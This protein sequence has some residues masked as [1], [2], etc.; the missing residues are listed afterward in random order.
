MSEKFLNGA[1]TAELWE[2]MKGYVDARLIGQSYEAGNGIEF[3]Q[4][5]SGPVKINVE[6]PVVPLTNADYEALPEEQKNS[7]TVFL[8]TD[9]NGASS[10]DSS[11]YSGEVYS[12]EESR[13][14]TWI[15]GKPLYRK[16]WSTITPNSS[17]SWV[18][19]A[20]ASDL[21]V[22][23]CVSLSG[24]ETAG[25]EVIPLPFL[26]SSSY[27]YLSYSIANKNIRSL[28]NGTT[29]LNRPIIIV[30]EYTKTT[31]EPISI[32]VQSLFLPGEL[33]EMAK[34]ITTATTATTSS[35]VDI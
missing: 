8:V 20:D 31:D 28:L 3:T 9:A 2:A 11:E 34:Y 24:I 18:P 27:T 16:V 30:F 22:E 4:T 35:N 14:G 25:D 12:T 32:P 5:E 7:E 26:S 15:D 29:H 23:T 21:N 33:E 6:C 10:E 17:G 1:R 19:I 13:I